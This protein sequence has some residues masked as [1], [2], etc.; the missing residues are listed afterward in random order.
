MESETIQLLSKDGTPLHGIIWTCPNPKAIICIVHGLGEHSGRYSHVAEHFTSNDVAVFAYDQRGHGLSGGKRGHT[1]SYD[2]LLDD[3][4]ELLKEARVTHNDL[5]IFLY[6]HS[7]G[8]NVVTNYALIRSTNELCGLIISSPW[9]KLGS[10]PPAGQVKMAKVV[11]KIL[12][13]LTQSNGLNVEDIS[14]DESAVEAYSKDPLVHDK[15]STRLFTEVYNAGL[16]AIE[17]ADGLKNPMLV[18]HGSDD[19]IT[20]PSGSEE[21]VERAGSL[22]EF[23]LWENMKHETHNDLRKEEVISYMHQWVSARIK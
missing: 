23:K 2:I 22:A 18:F 4:E 3:V 20:S 1:P 7:F 9:L 19:N 15:I 14:T 21:F 16:W 17:Y 8:G 5:P 11:S 12:P 6:G 13:S 10:E